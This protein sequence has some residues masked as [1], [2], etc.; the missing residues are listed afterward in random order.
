M[1][2]QFTEKILQQGAS[3]NGAWSK[4][5]FLALDVEWDN[6]HCTPFKGWK[7]KLIGSWVE[8]RQIGEFLRLKN[9]HLN[10]EKAKNRGAKKRKKRKSMKKAQNVSQWRQTCLERDDY[11][12]QKCKKRRRKGLHVHHIKPK[13]KF[14]KLQLVVS[15]GKSLCR[16]CHNLEHEGLLDYYRDQAWLKTVANS[17]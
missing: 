2:V 15:N 5:Q 3:L 16:D 10:S 14:P 1:L 11:T 4:K 9:K 8:S 7:E 17:V 13:Y 12:C 6:V